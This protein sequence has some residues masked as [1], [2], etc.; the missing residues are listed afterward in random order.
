[1]RPPLALLLH[2]AKRERLPLALRPRQKPLDTMRRA[3]RRRKRARPRGLAHGGPRR[4]SAK[5]T[6]ATR[7][8]PRPSGNGSPLTD[9]RRKWRSR[10]S[11]LRRS[12]G[13]TFMRKRNKRGAKLAGPLAL[14]ALWRAMKNARRAGRANPF[15]GRICQ[16]GPRWPPERVTPRRCPAKPPRLRGQWD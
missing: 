12:S 8:S 11:G 7:R 1:M 9:G 14:P 10:G 2:R 13:K 6:S 4:R 3:M 16:N 15:E 5:R